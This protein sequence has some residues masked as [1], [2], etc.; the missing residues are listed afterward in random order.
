MS[1]I[2]MGCLRIYCQIFEFHRGFFEGLA[3]DKS[4]NLGTSAQPKVCGTA[5][6]LL[7]SL[8]GS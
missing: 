6:V 3:E 4:Y 1:D 2:W 8:N 7:Q 5:P